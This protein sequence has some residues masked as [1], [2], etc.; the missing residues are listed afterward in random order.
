MTVG[1]E[2]PEDTVEGRTGPWMQTNSG[3]RFFPGDP[4]P[5]D[6]CMNDIA[7]GLALDCRYGGQGNVNKFYSVAEHCTHLAR[8]VMREDW[9]SLRNMHR[10]AFAVLLH[11]AAEAYLND[12]PRAV[13]KCLPE[14]D[15]LEHSVQTVIE[16]KYDVAHTAALFSPY[17][18]TLDQ[19]IVPLEKAAVHPKGLRWAF[20]KFEPLPHIQIG[21]WSA[22]EAKEHFLA[23]YATICRGLG[24]TPEGYWL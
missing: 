1:N 24:I 23:T 9:T 18:K 3:K 19:S 4:R 22:P 10:V 21:C 13:K 6:I 11:D 8:Y 5:E 14:Y 17:I 7:N 15:A 12:L 16:A 20:D 2:G